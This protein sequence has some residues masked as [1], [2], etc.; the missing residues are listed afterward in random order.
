[1]TA[2][3]A[4]INL[5]QASS[6]DELVANRT[7]DSVND[8]V[9]VS[10]S[11]LAEQLRPL[12]I[13]AGSIDPVALEDVP[14]TKVVH[15]IA[16]GV[17]F[18][19][20]DR[21]K[22]DRHLWDYITA[23]NRTASYDAHDE[24]QA[25]L[26]TGEPFRL[27]AATVSF[28]GTLTIS[29]DD[30]II[31]GRGQR[32]ILRH[33]DAAGDFFSAPANVKGL[34]W[35][36]IS[37]WALAPKTS[38]VVLRAYQLQYAYFYDI[39]FGSKR[40]YSAAGYNTHYLVG[41]LDLD[42]FADVY[43]IGGENVVAGEAFYINGQVIGAGGNLLGATAEDVD[44]EG[45]EDAQAYGAEF[46][47]Q[48]NHRS[49]RTKHLIRAGGA[50]GGVNVFDAECS[51]PTG[52]AAV[53]DMS[54]IKAYNREAKFVGSRLD[55]G[56][57]WAVDVKG[58]CLT[59]LDADALWVSGFGQSNDGSGGW[60]FGPLSE[61]TAP[62]TAKRKIEVRIAGGTTQKCYG[63]GFEFVEGKCRV[64]NHNISNNGLGSAGGH[65]FHAAGGSL[66]SSLVLDGNTVDNNGSASAVIGG[67]P[68]GYGYRLDGAINKYTVSDTVLFSNESGPIYSDMGLQ[69]GTH[70]I[71]G[72]TGFQT[73]KKGTVEWATGSSTLVV[74]HN[75]GVTPRYDAVPI[76]VLAGTPPSTT[77][78]P[79]II[80]KTATTTVWD[81]GGLNT[82]GG[83]ITCQWEVN[84]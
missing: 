69:E 14:T 79:R 36:D 82:S 47:I 73:T 50:A 25:A 40:L 13:P 59:D 1:M 28:S 8:V 52:A 57:S 74:N 18:I 83:P 51:E 70:E 4:T 17:P 32:T 48:G 61:T 67:T 56:R 15:Q 27:P 72:L 19:M 35:R 58:G 84:L 5:P 10:V 38:G 33:L 65:G 23:A 63:S 6:V 39:R 34:T 45:Y 78:E 53:Y 81:M 42:G 16:G 9:R 46:T 62:V 30:C 44:V 24:L 11:D 37:F 77:Y 26:D 49:F 41:A 2:P 64:G 66:I 29:H 68:Q 3:V 54:R 22:D 60:R 12:I 80:D 75:L 55:N 76:V 20:A 31:E 71:S 43:V 21:L 7:Q